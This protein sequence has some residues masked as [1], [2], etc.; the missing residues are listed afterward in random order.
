[1][2]H[3][4]A[5]ALDI[6]TKVYGFGF[7]DDGQLSFEN[8]DDVKVPTLINFQH[9][10]RQVAVGSYHSMILSEHGQVY[11][12]GRND[13]GALG[14]DLGDTEQ[15]IL[16]TLIEDIKDENIMEI[17]CGSHHSAAIT[18]EGLLYMWGSNEYGQIGLGED[19]D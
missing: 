7:N 13:F 5:L 6:N 14:L 11:A 2:Y 19:A 10:V 17:A 12:F 4:H 15:H 1:M 18:K 3:R 9:Q 8:G 16:P